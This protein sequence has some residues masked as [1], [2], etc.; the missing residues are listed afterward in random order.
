VRVLRVILDQTTLCMSR[1]CAVAHLHVLVSAFEAGAWATVSP[2]P[3]LARNLPAVK[4][5]TST[6]VTLTAVTTRL[7]YSD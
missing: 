2:S 6:F 7:Q 5:S 3:I 1:C 4:R